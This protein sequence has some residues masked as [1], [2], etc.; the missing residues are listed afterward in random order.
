MEKHR[1]RLLVLLMAAAVALLLASCATAASD[2]AGFAGTLEGKLFDIEGNPV[3]VEA[4]YYLVYYAADWCPYCKVFQE[5]LK[6]TYERLQR[7]YGNVQI[8]FA[9]HI[10][11]TGNQNMVDF[12]TQG[13]YSFPY[14]GYEYREQTGIMNLVDVPKFWIPGFVLVDRSGKVL[15]SSNGQTE[16]DYCRDCPIQKYESLQQ[17]DCQKD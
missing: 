9:G 12:L 2:S 4:D 14:V 7:M 17:C 6:S 16:E 1:K 5:Q 15:S 13:G 8:I 3:S 11:D 10:R